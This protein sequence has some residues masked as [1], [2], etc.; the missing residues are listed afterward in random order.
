MAA[1]SRDPRTA[2]LAGKSSAVENV[3]TH[4]PV[5][6]LAGEPW[7]LDPRQRLQ[8]RCC[9]LDTLARVMIVEGWRDMPNRETTAEPS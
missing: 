1:E 6:A 4:S 2:S 3:L 7:R 9:E 8:V 5:A